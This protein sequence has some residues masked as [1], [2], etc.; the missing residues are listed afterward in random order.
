MNYTALSSS[1]TVSEMDIDMDYDSKIH[2]VKRKL[3]Y[4]MLKLCSCRDKYKSMETK[5]CN[6]KQSQSK[7]LFMLKNVQSMEEDLHKQ[8]KNIHINYEAC[9]EKSG[10]YK[11]LDEMLRTKMNELSIQRNTLM[12]ELVQL[13]K[14]VDDNNK[15][16]V[17]VKAMITEQEVS[18]FNDLYK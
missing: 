17:R 2:Q 1:S 9:I 15:K 3:D 13:R 14:N 12:E 4:Y 11:D 6:V 18:D 7:P 16:L 10:N 5:I 8:F